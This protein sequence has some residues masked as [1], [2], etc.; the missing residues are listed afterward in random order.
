LY[1][2][3]QQLTKVAEQCKAFGR[4]L[5]GADHLLWM[6]PYHMLRSLIHTLNGFLNFEYIE[7][8]DLS[9]SKWLKALFPERLESGQPN[10]THQSPLH[11]QIIARL[12]QATQCMVQQTV[13]K[14]SV[15][16][17]RDDV[18]R[19]FFHEALELVKKVSLQ[20]L[21]HSRSEPALEQNRQ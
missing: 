21:S 16:S 6:N 20:N 9:L 19:P 7:D 11:H 18:L 1:Q 2:T 13:R 4:R 12:T 8:T 3:I 15:F 10:P 17:Q 5:A 14:N